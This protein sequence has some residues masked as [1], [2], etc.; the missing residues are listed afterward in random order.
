ME[1]KLDSPELQEMLNA[2]ILTHI[3]NAMTSY[4]VGSAIAS[5][6]GETFSN[7]FLNQ[8][9]HTA[10]KDV[11]VKELTKI[12]TKELQISVVKGMKVL[13]QE[14]LFSTVKKLRGISDYGEEEKEKGRKLREEL[15]SSVSN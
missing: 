9:I 13:M 15:F 14:A 4:Q 12:L 1:I 2:A 7:E 5:S 8:L 6:V 3:Q 10:M 11:N